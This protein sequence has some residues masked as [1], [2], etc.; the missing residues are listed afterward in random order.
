MRQ[1]RRPNLSRAR[2]Q[3]RHDLPREETRPDRL[4]SGVFSL[5]SEH[6]DEGR[7]LLLS[8]NDETGGCE[9]DLPCSFAHEVEY[10]NGKGQGVGYVP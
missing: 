9:V 2:T 3:P 7:D 5:K 1:T 8:D 10:A 4:L 6:R